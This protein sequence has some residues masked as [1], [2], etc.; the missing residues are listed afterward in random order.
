MADKKISALTTLAQA[1]VAVTADFLPIVDT[2]A[3]E[4]KK[5]TP[6]AIVN[7]ATSAAQVA[8][9]AGSAASPAIVATG[10]TDTGVFFP[11]ANSLALSTAGAEVLRLSSAGNVHIGSTEAVGAKLRI[12]NANAFGFEFN[13]VDGIFQTYNRSSAA[14]VD[15]KLY[16]LSF[17]FFAGSSPSERMAIDSSGNIT[18]GGGTLATSATDGFL[19]VPTCAGTPTGT[20]TT[21][22]GFSPIVVNTTN[23][24]LYF[25]SGGAWRDA[26]P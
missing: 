7:A 15:H 14:Y 21:K 26:G 13:V 5:A 10:D 3:T 25:Y 6:S 24:K 22:T 17:R 8:F 16:S 2:S 20:P 12:S 11:A 4:T 19:Y 18:A 9:S 23:N 1:D